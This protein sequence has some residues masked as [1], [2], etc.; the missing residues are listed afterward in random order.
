MIELAS[1]QASDE[2][3]DN[4]RWRIERE[5]QQRSGTVDGQP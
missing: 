1:S 3:S 4:P 2:R 5:Q